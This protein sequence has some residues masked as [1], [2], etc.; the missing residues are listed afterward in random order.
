[1]TL[2]LK[3]SWSRPENV[4][5]P[6]TWSTF[7]A[8]DFDSDELVEYEIRDVTPDKFEEVFHLM[9]TDYMLNEPLNQYFGIR[10]LLTALFRVQFF[11]TVFSN[12]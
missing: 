1:M 6:V 3:L 7:R 10:K 8:K 4:P 5:Y 11:F 2:V 12:V 9:S